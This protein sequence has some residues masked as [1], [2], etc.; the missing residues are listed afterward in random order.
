[1]A[2]RTDFFERRNPQAILKH[3]ILTRFAV[4]FA[5]RGLAVRRAAGSH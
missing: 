4:Y 2:A 1:M 3:G 5:G